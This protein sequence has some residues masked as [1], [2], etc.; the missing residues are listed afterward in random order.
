MWRDPGKRALWT[1]PHDAGADP[2]ADPEW[3]KGACEHN[4]PGRRTRL[5]THTVA[6]HTGQVP[7][8]GRRVPVHGSLPRMGRPTHVWL[9]AEALGG[10]PPGLKRPSAPSR[11][12]LSHRN[13]TTGTSLVAQ[14]LRI[15]LP[16]QG[17]R[18]RALVRE[19]PTC[20]GATEPVRHNY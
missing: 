11:P 16:V 2:D 14:W 4:P 9:S 5:S 18:V 17:T 12:V 15:R 8:D 7:A 3:V 1:A 10:W 13:R 20:R 19:D 6:V